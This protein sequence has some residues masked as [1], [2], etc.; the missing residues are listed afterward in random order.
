MKLQVALDRIS[1]E[2]AEILTTQLAPYADIIEL[3]TSLVKDYGNLAIS[4]IKARCQNAVL[5]VDS[6]TIDEGAY[7]FHQ[8]FKY[9][10][11]LITVMGAA[12]LSTL[13]TCYAISEETQHTMVIDLLEVPTDKIAKISHFDHAIYAL[14]HSVDRADPFDALATVSAFTK[15]FPMIKRLAIAGGIDLKTAKALQQQGI[16]EQVIVGSAITKAQD[17]IHACKKF[18]E[19]MAT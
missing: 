8:G 9:G 17:P 18:K 12:S 15:Q 2:Q 4:T 19:A 1:L 16:I 3:G 7:E 11:D 13:E 14:H 10:A 6:K 5:L